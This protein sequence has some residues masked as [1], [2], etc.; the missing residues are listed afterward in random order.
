[1]VRLLALAALVAGCTEE[2]ASGVYLCGPEGLCPEGMVCN[3]GVGTVEQA[4]N[5]CVFPGNAEAFTCGALSDPPGD[6]APP[7]GQILANLGCVSGVLEAKGCLRS[8]DVGDWFQFDAPANCTAVQVVAR[9]TFPIAFEPIALQIA[10]NGAE[11]IPAET[12]CTAAQAPAPGEAARCFKQTLTN[13][14]HHSL[15][16]VHA[17]FENCDGACRSNRYKLLLQLSTP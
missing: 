2:I 11:P 9:V 14:S 7:N 10:T 16:L 17:G 6:D 12:E 8:E 3:G 5:V 13:G 4:G 15:G 1:V